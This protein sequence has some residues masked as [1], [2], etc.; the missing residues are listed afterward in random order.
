[1]VAY[2]YVK[3]DDRFRDGHWYQSLAFRRFNNFRKD[4]IGVAFF[5]YP[6]LRICTTGVIYVFDRLIGF[7][8]VITIQ[9]RLPTRQ[10]DRSILGFWP[11]NVS[12]TYIFSG[13]F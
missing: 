11:V 2:S 6:A 12:R 1:M 5:N 3:I 4:W 7:C 13:L 8:R 10:S 9:F